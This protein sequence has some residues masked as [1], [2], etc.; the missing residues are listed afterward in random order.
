MK[1]FADI[2]GN[3]IVNTGKT[4]GVQSHRSDI[5]HKIV[6]NVFRRTT[7]KAW[8]FS[9]TITLLGNPPVTGWAVIRKALPCR[10]VSWLRS[11]LYWW[12]LVE[13]TFRSPGFGIMFAAYK[14]WLNL[15]SGILWNANIANYSVINWKPVVSDT[16]C[17]KGYP[18]LKSQGPMQSWPTTKYRL[19]IWIL[20]SQY[21]IAICPSRIMYYESR[22]WCILVHKGSC[23][24]PCTYVIK[25]HTTLS[26]A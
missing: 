15:C 6:K 19:A 26:L 7:K 2:N 18:S 5:A 1:I 21:S 24:L 17:L 10:D 11:V 14:W 9:I 4:L 12:A 16:F 20:Y 13:L 23:V 3:A 22:G 8:K 25:S